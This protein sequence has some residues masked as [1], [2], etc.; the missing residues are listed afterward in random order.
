MLERKI[1]LGCA[2]EMEKKK[3]ELNFLLVSR[4]D[5]CQRRADVRAPLSRYMLHVLV[6]VHKQQMNDD[7]T[8][9]I[10]TAGVAF[11]VNS[12]RTKFSNKR[13]EAKCTC[14]KSVR[15]FATITRTHNPQWHHFKCHSNLNRIYMQQKTHA[16][17]D[18]SS[19]IR[20]K[21]SLTY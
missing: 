13:K 1:E 6:Y 20:F 16:Q 3:C 15:C 19:G 21:S 7:K 18:Y 12:I 10:Y 9:I 14:M 2:S 17:F 8:A 4:L 5:W 11:F